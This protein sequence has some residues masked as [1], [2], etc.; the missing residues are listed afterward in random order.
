MKVEPES[1]SMKKRRRGAQPGNLNALKNGFYSRQLQSGELSDLEKVRGGNL[2]DEIDMLRVV[3]R[4]TLELSQEYETPQVMMKTLGALG[5]AS[6]RIFRLMEAQKSLV[7]GSKD[8]ARAIS[9][10]LDEV[11]EEMGIKG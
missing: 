8:V 1:S 4:R 7:E 3:M 5:L 10:A 9:Q 6:I 2:Q 11:M